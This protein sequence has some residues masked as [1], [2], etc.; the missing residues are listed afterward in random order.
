MSSFFS[1]ADLASCLTVTLWDNREVERL[2]HLIFLFYYYWKY[3]MWQNVWKF[4]LMSSVS[5]WKEE[6]SEFVCRT[7]HCAET[8]V[9]YFNCQGFNAVAGGNLGG[10]KGIFIIIILKYADMAAKK[11]N[12]IYNSWSYSSLFW[13]KLLRLVLWKP[14]F[15]DRSGSPHIV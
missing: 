14:F 2:Y 3:K 11:K 1:F 6:S 13:L 8:D 15:N 10:L 12:R 7:Q 4:L 9:I 5:C